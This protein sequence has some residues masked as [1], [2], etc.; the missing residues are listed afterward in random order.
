M[1]GSANMA[2]IVTALSTAMGD[3]ATQVLSAISAILPEAAPVLGAVLIIGI[4]I[5]VFKKIAKG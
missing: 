4:G 1:E 3:V 5:R 2:S